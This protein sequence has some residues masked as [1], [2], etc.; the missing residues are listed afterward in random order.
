MVQEMGYVRDP[1]ALRAIH[2]ASEGV[3]RAGARGMRQLGSGVLDLCFVACGRIDA[4][5]AGVAGEGWM[6][7][8]HC[9]ASVIVL[10]AGGVM[11][12]IRQGAETLQGHSGTKS[13]LPK[14]R[15]ASNIAAASSSSSSS[16][17]YS[18]FPMNARSVLCA[19]SVQLA[20]ELAEAIE[21]AISPAG[22][23]NAIEEPSRGLHS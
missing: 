17:S 15:K 23:T 19:S 11:R 5:F 16:S 7:W 2:A 20:N 4:V 12:P 14:E 22:V 13:S 6:P 3:L 9:A 18:P 10:E 1:S 8:D 21:S